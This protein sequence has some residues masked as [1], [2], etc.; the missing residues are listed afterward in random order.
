MLTPTTLAGRTIIICTSD[1]RW[2]L[3]LAAA[4]EL[5]RAGAGVAFLSSGTSLPETEY[6]SFVLNDLEMETVERCF[7]A[8]EAQSGPL[9]GLVH[10]PPHQPPCPG[11]ALS[12]AEWRRHTHQVLD[13]S[14]LLTS[15]LAARCQA[16]R[17]PGT[18]VQV[19]DRGAWSGAP[20]QVHTA[21]ISAALQSMDKTLA[22]EWA[23]SDIRV[24]TIVPG[25]F[26][27]DTSPVHELAAREGRQL[28]RTLPA[29]RLG[30][31]QEFGWAVAFLCSPYAAYITGATFIIDGGDHLR[32]SISGPPFLTVPQ[33]SE[34][35]MR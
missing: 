35:A 12:L 24:N 9:Y 20:G 2:P 4:H 13:L 18:V 26:A 34:E 22:V 7:D 32:R 29:Q 14:F 21:A 15:R 16:Q 8:I 17:R 25:P 11:E 19:V 3:A 27:G 31:L 30:Q 1:D 23:R 6:P 33:W 10:L 5:A 28:E